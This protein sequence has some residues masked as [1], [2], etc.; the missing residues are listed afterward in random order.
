MVGTQGEHWERGKVNGK[1]LPMTEHEERDG[2]GVFPVVWQSGLAEAC[3]LE[4]PG[5]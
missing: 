1:D 4:E 5:I 2:P 3:T